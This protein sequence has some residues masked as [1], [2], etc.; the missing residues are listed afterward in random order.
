MK[1]VKIYVGCSLTQAPEWFRHSIEVFK[2]SLARLPNVEVLDFVG[3]TAGTDADVY[4]H[5][6]HRCV[7]EADLF[8]ADCSFPA[9]GLGWELGTA[10]EKLEKEVIA[11]A[12]RGTKVTRLVTGASSPRNPNY[13]FMFYNSMDEVFDAVVARLDILQRKRA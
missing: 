13:S 7:R 11:V 8:V 2:A 3:L 9:I 12:K 10:V 6:I 1:K 4:E 5:D